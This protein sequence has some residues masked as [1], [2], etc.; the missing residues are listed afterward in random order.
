MKRFLLV[1]G[2]CLACSELPELTPESLSNTHRFDADAVEKQNSIL[3]QGFDR[4]SNSS[5]EICIQREDINVQVL[6]V[7]EGS[8]EVNVY[9]TLTE[10]ATKLKLGL[11]IS[12]GGGWAFVN[13]AVGMDIEKTWKVSQS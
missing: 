2:L 6:E 10:L 7:N 1:A 9:E 11:G 8:S 3:L 12:G 13:G 5:N 4:L